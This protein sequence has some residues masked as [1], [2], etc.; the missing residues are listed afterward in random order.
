MAQVNDIFNKAKDH[1]RAIAGDAMAISV[2]ENKKLLDKLDTLKPEKQIVPKDYSGD[3]KAIETAVKNQEVAET[4]TIKNPEAIT[5]DLKEGL[6]DIVATL[7]TEIKTLGD[8]KIEVKNDLGQLATL[9]KS[10]KDK[11]AVLN[12][13]AKIEG[14]IKEIEI[15]EPQEVKDTTELL[16]KLIEAVEGRES[17]KEVLGE[18][19]DKEFFLPPVLDVNLDPNLIH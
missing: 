14:A 9:F 16:V 1:L 18:I 7:K 4:V 11:T 17:L 2:K 10:S 8:K 6:R 3:L 12:G 5:G 13:L 15:P 19:R